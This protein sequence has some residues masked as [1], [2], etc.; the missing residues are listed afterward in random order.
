[1]LRGQAQIWRYLHGDIDGMAIRCCI[2][3]QI[4]DIISNHGR[5]TTLS[6]ITNAIDSRSI[7]KDGLGRLMRFLVHKKVFDEMPQPQKRNEEG[8]KAYSLN[9][10]SKWLLYDTDLTLAPM[11]M[12]RTNP[13]MALH[14][15]VLSRSI[16]EG[17][18]TFKMTQG[19][20]MFE[21]SL[22]NSEFNRIFNE[23]MAST[24]RIT[25]DSI[26]SKYNNGFLGLIGSV[27]DVGGGTRVAIYEIVKAYPHLKGINFD[28]SHVISIAPTYDGVTHVVGDMFMTIPLA[29]TIFMKWILH[30][31]SDEDCIK[32]LKF[33]KERT[34]REWKKLLS[35]G[36]FCR[37]NIIKIPAL[38]SIIE[39]F[40]Q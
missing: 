34:E 16:K 24:T 36:G 6:E 17:G 3:H 7:N 2:E 28:L 15:H 10:C 20:E 33:G 4:A 37:Y 13:L 35:G 27:G 32:I 30:D 1:M 39:A 9:C 19:K 26:M 38:Q 18:T 21:F 25:M 23:G 31:W 29:E 5:P 12:L 22:H 11:F 14:M 40:P 8:E